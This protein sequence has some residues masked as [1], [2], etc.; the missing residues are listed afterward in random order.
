M[1]IDREQLK[2][3]AAALEIQNIGICD[4]AAIKLREI[5]EEPDWEGF[6]RSVIRIFRDYDMIDRFEIDVLIGYYGIER[7]GFE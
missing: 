3:L 2:Q 7:F 1:N 4:D 6:G 5:A